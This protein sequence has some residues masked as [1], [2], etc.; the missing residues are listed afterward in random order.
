MRQSCLLLE[1][2]P[3]TI[4]AVIACNAWTNLPHEQRCCK[5]CLKWVVVVACAAKK[6]SR[7][8]LMVIQT[9]YSAFIDN[10]DNYYFI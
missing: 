9:V 7:A 3:G 5:H 6:T 2:V 1:G 10:L 4:D 8:S